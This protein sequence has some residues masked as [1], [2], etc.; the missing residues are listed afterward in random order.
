M[1]LGKTTNKF[2]VSVENIE[3]YCKR[4][5]N[6][7]DSMV[8]WR[9]SSLGGCCQTIFILQSYSERFKRL[10]PSGQ[11]GDDKVRWLSWKVKKSK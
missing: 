5:T 3:R 4:H 11:V 1:I 10:R 8:N 7:A 6:M 2:R 9:L